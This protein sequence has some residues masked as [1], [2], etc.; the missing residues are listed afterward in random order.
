MQRN[1]KSYQIRT[2]QATI[3]I[4]GTDFMLAVVNPLYFSVLV[5]SIEVANAAG[6][7]TF[8]AG[9]TG[10]AANANALAASLAASSMPAAVTSAFSQL[11]AVP[12]GAAGAAGAAAGGVSPAA[13]A[14]GAAIAA[15]AAAAA[16][17][18]G[19]DTPVAPTA[20]GTK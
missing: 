10:F 6:A 3:G 4:R 9:A 13:I 11:A 19:S 2:P 8:P 7:A 5:G 18:G 12:L 15:G 14:V 20:T 17:G 16:G 1:P